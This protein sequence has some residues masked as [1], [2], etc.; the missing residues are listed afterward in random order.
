MVGAFTDGDSPEKTIASDRGKT[1]Y[2]SDDDDK[3]FKTDVEDIHA[4]GQRN[5]LPVFK[6]SKDEFYSNMKS[7]RKRLRFKSGTKMQQY[8]NKTRYKNPFFIEYEGYLRKIK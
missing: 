3:K 5:G 6:V 4:D 8:M 7:D 1:E 2:S